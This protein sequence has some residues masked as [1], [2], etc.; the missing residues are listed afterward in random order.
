MYSIPYGL[1][2]ENKQTHL[3]LPCNIFSKN[4]GGWGGISKVSYNCVLNPVP[5]LSILLNKSEWL[6]EAY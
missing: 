3:D 4:G 1:K 6:S 2:K 5:D